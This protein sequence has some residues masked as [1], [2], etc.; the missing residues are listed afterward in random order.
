MIIRGPSW[1]LMLVRGILGVIL[2]VMLFAWPEKSAE[3]FVML[4]GLFAIVTGLLSIFGAVS[5]RHHVWGLSLTSGILTL[6]IG[7]VAF[8]WP[9][10]TATVLVWLVAVWAL[11]FG[12]MEILAGARVPGGET[13]RAVAMGIGLVT[14]A[15]GSLLLIDPGVGIVAASLL[16]GLYFLMSGAL[17]IYHALMVRSVGRTVTVK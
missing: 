9:G 3:A 10:I 1:G 17:T 4:F 5:A 7:L 12:V 8:L 2:G 11:V 15:L 16:V 13:L 6:L 14:V